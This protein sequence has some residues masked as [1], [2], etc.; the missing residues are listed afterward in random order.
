LYGWGS[1]GSYFGKNG[2]FRNIAA[3]ILFA[4]PRLIH[5][6]EMESM[7]RN[8]ARPATGNVAL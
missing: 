3:T 1:R 5:N 2:Y 6:A 7:Y 8:P 4:F